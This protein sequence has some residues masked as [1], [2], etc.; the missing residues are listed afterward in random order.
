M[1]KLDPLLE[2]AVR[3]GLMTRGE[4]EAADAWAEQ[5]AKAKA[6][7]VITEAE[8]QR[9]IIERAHADAREHLRRRRQ[10]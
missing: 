1:M 2:Q 4:A 8:A 5:L 9:Q 7:G 3:A 10:Y 6:A